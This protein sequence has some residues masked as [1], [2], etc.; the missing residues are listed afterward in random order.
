M[1][2][3][4]RSLP[5]LSEEPRLQLQHVTPELRRGRGGAAYKAP[6]ATERLVAIR[7][8][9]LEQAADPRIEHPNVTRH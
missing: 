2:R 9:L 5:D 6:G 7:S 1:K 4:D 3:H 8:A